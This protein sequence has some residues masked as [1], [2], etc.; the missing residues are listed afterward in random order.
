MGTGLKRNP[1]I[2]VF[3]NLE[4]RQTNKT[5]LP[6]I[7][8]IPF[9]RPINSHLSRTVIIAQTRIKP[10]AC[11]VFI[12]GLGKLPKELGL[13]KVKIDIRAVGFSGLYQNAPKA[14][15]VN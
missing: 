3:T 10:Y 14:V 13:D 2:A 15:I 8:K 5:G 12:F 1:V 4:R 7:I 6:A 11:A 9:M